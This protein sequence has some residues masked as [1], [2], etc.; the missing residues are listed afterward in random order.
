MQKTKLL[1]FMISLLISL[2]NFAAD[3]NYSDF[4]LTQTVP[5]GTNL[6]RPNMK[7]TRDVWVD[8]VNGAQK[9]IC[10]GSLYLYS[11][12]GK[13]LEPFID[14]LK[15]AA[16]RNVKIKIILDKTLYYLSKD[17]VASLKG[18]KNID[19]RILPMNKLTGGVM[20]AKYMVVD[21][22]N[23]YVGSS[24]FGWTAMK[25][26]H[27]IGVRI[28]SRELASTILMIFDLD[29]KMCKLG[30]LTEH[31]GVYRKLPSADA[32]VV[33]IERPINI[34]YNDEIL[35]IH[36]AFSPKTM[37]PD[38]VDWGQE[39]FVKLISMAKREAVFQVM[40]YS[41]VKGYGFVGY[42]DALEVALRKAAVRGVK[43]KF[44]VS[45]WNN[46]KPNIDF[47]KSLAAVPNIDVKISSIPQ[48][49]NNFIPYTRVEHCK[50][51]VIDN[52]LTW[53]GNGNWEWSYFNNTRDIDIIIHGK[54]PAKQLKDMFIQDW[55]GP[56]VEKIDLNKKY[57]LPKIN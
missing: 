30:S 56:Y 14:A 50:Y 13:S 36:P 19:I 11:K 39:Q 24:N 28:R 34:K 43:I 37:N 9:N 20:H 52:D 46:K 40:S 16:V 35:S 12:K 53:I 47:I 3:D 4:E 6:K 51:F 27:N 33:S 25:Q 45:N 5:E 49:K 48:L 21:N 38:C 18:I 42:W 54:G 26:I 32:P 29:W 2:N 44:I 31:P 22:E 23:V 17:T 55:N 10:F 15:R 41:P 57:H 8:M 1:I 7:W